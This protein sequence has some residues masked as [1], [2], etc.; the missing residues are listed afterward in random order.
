M[1]VTAYKNNAQLHSNNV[2]DAIMEIL[3]SKCCF[4]ICYVL[5]KKTR[6]T[7]IITRVPFLL[8]RQN[9]AF[10]KDYST[11]RWVIATDIAILHQHTL[12]PQT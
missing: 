9:T 11:R 6:L 10:S 8:S 12:P 5:Q 1:H 2:D 4:S 3:E 7:T